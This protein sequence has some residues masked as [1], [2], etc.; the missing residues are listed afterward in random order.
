MVLTAAVHAGNAVGMVIATIVSFR[1]EAAMFERLGLWDATR[2][3]SVV[4][5]ASE[6]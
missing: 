6:R 2:R 4:K 3:R 1:G 5:T